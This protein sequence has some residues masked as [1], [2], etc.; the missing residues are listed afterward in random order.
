MAELEVDL[1]ASRETNQPV[2]WLLGLGP[3]G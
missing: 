2:L 3:I 1:V